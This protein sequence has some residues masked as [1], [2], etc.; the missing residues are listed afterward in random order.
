M[1]HWVNN[2]NP[3]VEINPEGPHRSTVI[4]LHGLGA[5]GHDFEPVARELALPPKLGVRFV[6]PHAPY[7]P[8][9]FNGGYVMRAWYDILA[10]DLS[11]RPDET[12]IRASQRVMTQLIEQEGMR[13]IE[14]SRI[15]IAGFSQGGVIAL[16]TAL[17]HPAPLAGV[18]AL[19]TYLALPNHR[20]EN[21]Q[22]IPILMA[23]GTQDTIV[24]Y[25][26]G[27]RSRNWLQ[28]RGYTVEWHSYPM[29][30]SV[31]WEEIVAIRDWL[32]RVL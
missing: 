26:L 13:G 25:A 30:H 29:P 7:L 6:F 21:I 17:H 24:P 9:T 5:D 2:D 28:E 8:V 31:C 16:E 12:G 1:E 3:A 20:P 19:S 23:H 15:V 32:L 11:L 27:E 22:P 14:P 4:W 18:I 10:S